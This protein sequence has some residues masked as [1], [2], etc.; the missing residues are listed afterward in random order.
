LEGVHCTLS[1]ARPERGVL[2][3]T[4]A[5]T[6]VGEFGRRPFEAMA[7]DLAAGPVE[8]FLD[9]RAG[10]AASIDVSSDWAAWLRE[11]R[12]RLRCIH[13]LVA[14][15]FI[16][17]SADLVRRF[18]GLEDRMR[19]YTGAVPFAEALVR[20]RCSAPQPPGT[21]HLS[22]PARGDVPRT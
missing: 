16:Q 18:A 17:L 21:R 12:E 13:M 10:K 22:R 1:I 4:F 8:L 20:A 15:K 19:L 5:G 9:A 14:T 3:V 2:V 6:D 7:P 11:Q